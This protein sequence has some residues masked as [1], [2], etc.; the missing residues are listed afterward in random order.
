MRI[1]IDARV[2]QGERRGQWRYAYCL[3]DALLKADTRNSYVLF[4][5]GFRRQPFVFEPRVNLEQVWCRVPGQLV[6]PFWEACPWP[7]VELLLGH[8][9]GVFHNLLNFNRVYFTPVPSACPMVATYHGV[10]DPKTLFD[11]FGYTLKETKRWLNRL[12]A[13][14]STVIAISELVRNNLLEY[15]SFPGEKIRVVYSGV[16]DRFL[17][18]AAAGP[19]LA[20]FGLEGKRFFFYV[21][22]M[23]KNKNLERLLRAFSSLDRPDTWLA[24]A[25]EISGPR[26]KE[27]ERMGNTRVIF[28]GRI[29]DDELVAFYRECL[30]FVLPT[31]YEG[32]GLPVLEAMACGA[33]V[34]VSKNTGIAEKVGEFVLQFD[35]L[36]T[37]QLR[38]CL[39]RICEDEPLRQS[40]KQRGQ[41]KAA[42]FTWEKTARQ[43][44]A[45]YEAYA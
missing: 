28:T 34:I 19:G 45:V 37:Q 32:F 38:A 41:G 25:G 29:S 1:G 3:I 40:M 11:S 18:P 8:R 23:E 9:L 27:L 6:K 30:A 17:L 21:G 10:A 42:E 5:H 44:I 43:V 31:I 16:E 33:P 12:A 26:K 22:G 24:I 2:L 14:A 39:K 13:G 4:Y 35:P 20:R 36:D 7:P 15:V